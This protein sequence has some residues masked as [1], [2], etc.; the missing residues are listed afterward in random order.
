MEA[1][2][3]E[4][5]RLLTVEKIHEDTMGA[6]IIGHFNGAQQIGRWVEQTLQKSRAVPGDIVQVEIAIRKGTP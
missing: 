6:H 2:S 5:L 3:E 4:E 1:M